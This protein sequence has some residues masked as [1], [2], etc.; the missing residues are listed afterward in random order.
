MRVATPPAIGR[1]PTV[2]S[3][4]DAFLHDFGAEAGVSTVLVGGRFT[5]PPKYYGV[6]NFQ[7]PDDCDMVIQGL[8][9]SAHGS[10]EKEFSPRNLLDF[11]RTTIN[12]PS[13][14]N[15]I[16][17]GNGIY[18]ALGS[19]GYLLK[20]TDG[21]NF[22]QFG[23]PGTTDI[24]FGNDVFIVITTG[25]N[26]WVQV[27][28][29]L[30]NW[31]SYTPTTASIGPGGFIVFSGN[32]FYYSYRDCPYF[33]T[34]VNGTQWGFNNIT[35]YGN[36]YSGLKI[37]GFSEAN[38][39]VF[40]NLDSYFWAGGVY[41]AMLVFD[42]FTWSW[43][44][45]FGSEN[46]PFPLRQLKYVQSG[47]NIAYGNGVYVALMADSLVYRS[48]DGETW[49][50]VPTGQNALSVSFNGLFL[51]LG[52]YQYSVYDPFIWASENAIAWK[53]EFNDEFAGGRPENAI[54]AAGNWMIFNGNG[55]AFFVSLFVPFTTNET[56]ESGV[57][58]KLIDK[59]TDR[60]LISDRFGDTGLPMSLL[61]AGVQRPGY[62]MRETIPIDH[63]Q[64][65]RSI[66]QIKIENAN[67]FPVT[68][69]F[70]LDC[71]AL[72]RGGAQ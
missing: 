8:R 14:L 5:V 30:E 26:N 70:V 59:Q 60:L 72:Y 7:I 56:L 58:I 32:L 34:S 11:R 12:S 17:Y 61:S 16:V 45:S 6:H 23:S 68:A 21:L 44:A 51:L 57:S 63:W 67:D 42:D 13:P 55:T 4:L 20:S 69:K 36:T 62:H 28:K 53:M 71:L 25:T 49:E 47:N 3:E 48:T 24:A 46:Q 22:T 66:I 40:M 52:G 18:L 50:V 9:A 1:S 35:A 37:T 39:K 2:P 64:K 10:R 33:Y 19:N 31:D 27:S 29:D 65:R 15:K 38:N 43:R 54:V 41:T